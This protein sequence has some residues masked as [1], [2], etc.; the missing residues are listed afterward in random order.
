[1]SPEF[2]TFFI[3]ALDDE[4][5]NLTRECRSRERPATFVAL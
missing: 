4:A 5:T 1:M 2:L 3:A